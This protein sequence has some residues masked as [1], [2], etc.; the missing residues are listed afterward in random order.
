MR[1]SK[2]REPEKKVMNREQWEKISTKPD[3]AKHVTEVVATFGGPAKAMIKVDGVL[4][5]R[6]GY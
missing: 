6:Y 1:D 2:R 3:M 4:I 5:V